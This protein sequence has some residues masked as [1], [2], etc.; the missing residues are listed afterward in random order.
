MLLE[1]SVR[2]ASLQGHQLGGRLHWTPSPDLR[3][4]LEVGAALTLSGLEQPG[5]F[6]LEGVTGGR[7]G[8]QHGR[9]FRSQLRFELRPRR[10]LGGRDYLTGTFVDAE[11]SERHTHGPWVERVSVGLRRNGLGR[12]I[13]FVEPGEYPGC[14]R[15]CV[16]AS[17]RIP[18]SYQGPRLT[19]DVRLA[20]TER[21]DLGIVAQFEYRAYLDDSVLVG[22]LVPA[23]LSALSRKARKDYRSRLGARAEYRV[24]QSPE[25]RLWGDYSVLISR[26]NVAFERGHPTHGLDY[27]NNNFLQHI[28]G[29]GIEVAH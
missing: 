8:V 22:P 7:V 6:A 3:V 24:T 23:G 4:A 5:V 10:G 15:A 21:V 11:I 2:N 1:P 29:I 28:I 17:Y 26:S 16:G 14:N 19:A 18:L 25:L 27:D 13:A 9:D 12:Q 20:A